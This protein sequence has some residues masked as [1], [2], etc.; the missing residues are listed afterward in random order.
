MAEVSRKHKQKR[1]KKVAVLIFV[2]ILVLIAAVIAAWLVMHN[3]SS[4]TIARRSD[5][6]GAAA[7]GTGSVTENSENT[8]AS[9][10]TEG[11]QEV[12]YVYNDHLSNFLF[13]GIDGRGTVDSIQDM[14]D[15]GSSDTIVVVSYDR[16]EETIRELVIPR[17]TMAEIE[18]FNPMGRSLGLSID[19]LN[20]QYAYGDGKLRSCEITKTA[21]SKIL[22]TGIPIQGYCSMRMD[23]ISVLVDVL[24]GIDVT[25]PD[26]TMA[27]EEEGYKKGDVITLTSETAEHFLR[28][29]DTSI[30]QS[31]IDRQNRQ[32]AFMEG[33][34]KKAKEEA[35]RDSSLVTKF[36]DALE[37]Y[38][39]TNMGNDQF[40]KLLM[41]ENLGSETMPGE[42][43]EGDTHDEF[44]IDPDASEELLMEMFFNKK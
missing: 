5:S 31:A 16:A 27:D 36:Y 11:S 21:V 22:G 38:L 25:V 20:I 44:Y 26:D 32:K 8:A 17:D 9:A 34:L 13:L 39:V 10:E 12:S 1:K 43:I 2:I 18:T 40:T 7:S 24:G 42:G 28:F 37:P 4:Q 30:S 23:G 33:F 35:D 3:R 19:H 14:W 41:A 6:T 15:I 29:R